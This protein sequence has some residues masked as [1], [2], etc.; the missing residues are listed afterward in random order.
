MKVRG[1][2][3]EP[4]TPIP[5]HPVGVAARGDRL[6]LVRKARQFGGSRAEPIGEIRKR[7][8]AG[9]CLGPNS[10]KAELQRGDATPSIEKISAFPALHFRRA[11]RV[12]GGNHVD[13]SFPQAGPQAFTIFAFANWRRTFELS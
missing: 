12:I 8:A 4:G 11:G 7:K 1:V 13:G 2:D 5:D 6:F 3:L 9:P 10:R